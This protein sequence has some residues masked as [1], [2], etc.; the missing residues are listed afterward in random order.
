MIYDIASE[1]RK[2]KDVCGTEASESVRQADLSDSRGKLVSDVYE[3]YNNH[4]C[5]TL[6]NVDFHDAVLDWL[7]RQA[8]ITERATR[9]MLGDTLDEMNS[10]ITDMGIENAELQS[11]VNAYERATMRVTAEKQT[12]TDM[13]DDLTA[14]RDY[15]KNQV[16]KCLIS[17]CRLN[18]LLFSY[19]QACMRANSEAAT[20]ADKQSMLAKLREEYAEKIRKHCNK[21]GAELLEREVDSDDR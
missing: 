11:K 12:L 18:D 10:Q 1:I 3:F 13:L 8:S 9:K 17:A 16:H 6:M 21:C 4:E 20:E 19:G 7:D 15:W 2:A 14:E 5:D